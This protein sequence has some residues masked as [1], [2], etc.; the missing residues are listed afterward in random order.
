M[1][2]GYDRPRSG[3]SV[4][5]LSHPERILQNMS[6]RRGQTTEQAQLQLLAGGKRRPDWEL[7]ERTRQIGRAGIEAVRETLR[8]AQPPTPFQKA[9]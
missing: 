5:L 4:T 8:R 9:S 6:E 1:P 7:D 3:R 2:P